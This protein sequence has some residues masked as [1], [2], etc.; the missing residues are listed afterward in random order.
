MKITRR[1]RAFLVGATL[2]AAFT[3]P[4]TIAAPAAHAGTVD[5]VCTVSGALNF[6]PALDTSEQTVNVSLEDGVFDD[7]TSSVYTGATVTLDSG[8]GSSLCLILD[9]T[10]AGQITWNDNEVSDF[11]YT[12]STDPTDGDVGLNASITSGP[13]AGDEILD[14]PLVATVN[15]AC[16]LAPISSLNLIVGLLVFTSV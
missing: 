1:A 12:I 3:V 7:C 9:L 4:A 15:G 10:G 8:S 13:F 11:N 6:S 2:S 5:N 16:V 14:A